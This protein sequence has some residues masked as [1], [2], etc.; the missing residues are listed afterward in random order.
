MTTR[1]HLRASF[2]RTLRRAFSTTDG[3]EI[4]ADALS[5][6]LDWR[7]AV[8]AT[9]AALPY[10][11][12]GSARHDAPPNY[13]GTVFITGRFRTGSTLVWNLFR[14]VDQAV[15]YYEPL[16]ERKWFDPS[17]RGD[18]LDPTHRDVDDYWREYDGLSDLAEW[19]REDWTDRAL[20]LRESA[21]NPG[22]RRYFDR[23]IEHAS[24]K[25]AVLQCNRLDFRLP[26]LRRQFPGA[27]LIHLYR[28]P[29]DQWCSTLV[30]PKAVPRDV[31]I[32]RF[33]PHDHFYLRRWA[34]DL[35][36]HFPFL[37]PRVESSPYRIFYY[38]WRLS[39]VFGIGYA[40]YSLAFER[41]LAS[42]A[43][44]ITKLMRVAGIATDIGRLV[45]L[46]SEAPVGRWR[47]F[48]DDTWFRDHESACETVLTEFFQGEPRP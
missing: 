19:H 44:E 31:T 4:A 17:T 45:P 6:L 36:H 28:H 26:W 13:R 33:E 7:P 29:R 8:P 37:S 5:G 30:N 10:D 24:P 22:L 43:E 39:Y 2:F 21:W 23:L 1:D 25:R 46:V 12:I 42:P 40:D 3:R 16:N 34:L 41:L 27:T 15:S 11:D 18:R 20:F 38:I 48:A 14:H 35:Q 32:D 47:Q 9:S